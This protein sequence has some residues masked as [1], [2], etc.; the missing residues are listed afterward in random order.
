MA[1]HDQDAVTLARPGS[2]RTPRRGVVLAALEGRDVPVTAQR[3]HAE[4]SQ[5]GERLALATVYRTLHAL[6]A[7]RAVHVFR[8]HGEDAFRRCGP[9]HHHH[10]ICGDCG[11]VVELQLPEVEAW[12]ARLAA[13]Q[14]F[15]VH[16]HRAD[17]YGSCRDCT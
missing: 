7:E 17:L 8:R 5:R 16:E 12:V 1:K 3:L 14:R 10:F 11:R 13:E 9:S 6:A 2:R 4:L 15:A